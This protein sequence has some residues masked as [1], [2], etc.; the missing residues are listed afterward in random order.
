[1]LST[2]AS[3]ANLTRARPFVTDGVRI[4]ASLL[5]CRGSRLV[6]DAL[7]SARFGRPSCPVR[8][9]APSVTATRTGVVRIRVRCAHGCLGLGGGMDLHL[10]RLGRVFTG[11]TLLDVSLPI[12]S[13]MLGDLRSS[14]LSGAL[15][16]PPPYPRS[17]LTF[18]W[19]IGHLQSESC[20]GIGLASPPLGPTGGM[21]SA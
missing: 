9:I 16:A 7:A 18:D 15:D 12:S 8:P 21:S 13:C 14:R 17:R 1:M 2:I 4:A 6:A 19:F 3:Y 11:E 20:S 5:T 10:G